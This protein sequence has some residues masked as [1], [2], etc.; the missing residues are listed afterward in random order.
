[1][2]YRFIELRTKALLGFCFLMA[3][4]MCSAQKANFEAISIRFIDADSGQPVEG[5]MLTQY[6]SPTST[7]EDLPRIS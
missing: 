1:M 5:I 2:R 6:P 4:A 3:F 7:F